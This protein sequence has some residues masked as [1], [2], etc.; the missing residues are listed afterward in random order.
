MVALLFVVAFAVIVW[1]AVKNVSLTAQLS[2]SRLENAEL[3]RERDAL[4]SRVEVLSKYEPIVDVEAHITREREAA[5]SAVEAARV[6]AVG[7][8]ADATQEATGLKLT[9]ER[10]VVEAQDQGRAIVDRANV[11]AKEIAGEALEAV[12]RAKELE[13][14]ARAMKNVIEGYGDRYLVP[15]FTVLDELGVE[16]GFSEAGQKLKQARERVRAMIKRGEAATC[17]YAEANRRETAIH[18][19]LDA[20]VGKSDA[21]LA[22]VRHDNFGTLHQKLKDAFSL[23]NKNGQAFRNARILPS[24][25]DA[26]VDELKWAVAAHELKQREREEQRVLKERL[27]EEERAQREFERAM[28]DAA[29]EEETLRKAMDK[30]RREVE[31]ASAEQ[32][33]GYEAKLAELTLRLQT[34]EEKNR[35]ALSMAQQTKRG[36]VYVI[37]NIGSFGEHIYKI[38]MTR[39]LEPLDRVRELGDASVPFEFDVHAMIRAEDAPALERELHKRCIRQQVNKVNPRKEFFRIG[40]Q[41]IRSIVESLGC[42]TAWTMTAECHDYKETLAIEQRLADKALPES[43]WIAQQMKVR[44]SM[45]AEEDADEMGLAS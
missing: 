2:K 38:G 41:D 10:R 40:L 22:D 34:A 5:R 33:A 39:R 43:A 7:I 27:R 35:R 20:F 29:K 13:D 23:V 17:D 31:R 21:V 19:V 8:I 9:A 3:G 15:T 25:L 16:L 14:V 6:Q 12:R 44:D 32:R 37:S 4:R 28:K 26:R 45:P 11:R 36:T 18:F 24:F 42:E 30:A 1:L